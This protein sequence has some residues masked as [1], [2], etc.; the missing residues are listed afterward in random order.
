MTSVLKT[1]Q[2]LKVICTP[3]FTN[4]LKCDVTNLPRMSLA[5][6]PAGCLF[7]T[8]PGDAPLHFKLITIVT[9]HSQ[10]VS[11]LL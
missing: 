6:H 2:I 5:P 4:T 9:R 10:E 11:E 3:A 1:V 7:I 8:L